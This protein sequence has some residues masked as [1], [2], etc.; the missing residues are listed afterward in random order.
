MR[1]SEQECYIRR[2][3]QVFQIATLRPMVS[4]YVTET[5][6]LVGRAIPNHAVQ[7]TTRQQRYRHG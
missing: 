6:H 7:H 3:I 2:F 4:I 5:A 1:H